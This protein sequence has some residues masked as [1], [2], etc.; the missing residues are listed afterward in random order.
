M[1]F[2]QKQLNHAK[3]SLLVHH[4]KARSSPM[5]RMQLDFVDWQNGSTALI[6]RILK[7]D[8]NAIGEAQVVFSRYF[9]KSKNLNMVVMIPK[10]MVTKARVIKGFVTHG[11]QLFG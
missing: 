9:L 6:H 4:L 1:N 3:K 5:S 7:T 2:N 11:F 10:N 8:L